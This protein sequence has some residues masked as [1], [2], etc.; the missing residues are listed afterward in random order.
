MIRNPLAHALAAA[1]YVAAP[2]ALAADGHLHLETAPTDLDGVVVL[3]VAPVAAVTFTTDPK[4]PRQPVP[5][6][7]GADYLRTIPGFS[8]LRS[9]G[10][11]GDPVL[12]GMFG[13]RIALLTNDGVLSGA[14]PSR[15]D[16]AMS[17]IAPESYDRLTVVKGPQT[18]LW[19]GGASAGTVRFERE[20]PYFDRPGVRAQGSLLAGS[21]GRNDQVLDASAG[22]PRGYLR[23]S[24]NRSE[25]DDYRAGD[26]RRVP[27]A[28]DKW[29]ADAAIG[30]TPD[31]D[32]VLELS[33]GT[34]DAE[35]R[36]AGRGMDG[37]RFRRDNLGLRFEK[38]HM[39]GVLDAVVASLYRNEVDHVMD[40]YTLRDP[41]PS[42]SMPMPMASNVGD[43]SQGG[44]VALT[45]QHDSWELTA[46]VDGRQGEH[47]RRSAMGRDAW[48][49][50]PWTHDADTGTLGVF[51]ESHW[52]IDEVHHLM[53]GLRVDR[54]R[55]EDRRATVG[56]GMN[57]M[58]NPT[59]GQRREETLAGG[60][61]R[62]E[63]D[64]AGRFGWYAG[65]GH[66]ERMPDYWELFSPTMGPQGAANAFAGV[67]PERTT[68]LDAGLQFRSGGVEAWASVYAGRVDDYIVFDYL[69]GGM[70]GSSTRARNLDADIAGA[71]LG[72][73]WKP[74]SGLKFGGALAYA[75]GRTDEGALPQM[76]PLEARLSAS[77][78]HG[79]WSWGALLRVVAAQHRTSTSQGNVV[80]RDL[81]SSPGFAVFS[82]NGGYRLGDHVRLA[83]GIDNLF[84]RDYR[85]HLNAAGNSGFGYPA[86]PER[87]AE[88]GRTAWLKLNFEY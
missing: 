88:P 69:P 79:D 51:A 30:W 22:T 43:T 11:N 13:S 68:Q 32:T 14:C 27:S 86:E 3:G 66:A 44:R 5:A 85:E 59:A 60:F 63:H 48:R 39:G 46:G 38:K 41:D 83:A 75:W 72:A 7:D 64:M 81:G 54:A 4:L 6:S 45:F 12:R 74:R 25:A 21:N 2:A 26:G 56:S 24:A 23:A 84:D 15:M 76:P 50:Q 35:A 65:L 19:G 40:N 1:L 55:A 49:Q 10:T 34:G 71:E 16:N 42:S 18:V 70:M 52:H 17:Y 8:T 20:I 67:Q 87:I 61:V 33:A 73:D 77:G 57:A 78:E 47:R 53:S 80:G 28:W 58:P 9:G 37:S 36:Y 62:Y 82:V 31:A 29:N